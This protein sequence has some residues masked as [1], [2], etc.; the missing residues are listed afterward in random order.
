MRCSLAH[1]PAAWQSG[2]GFL[3]TGGPD[4]TS[5]APGMAVPAETALEENPGPAR[6]V[7]LS[8]VVPGLNEER[9]I[10]ALVERLRPVLDSL[11]LDWE[12]IFVDDGST[13]GTMAVLQVAQRPRSALQG[14]LAQPQ[15]RQGDRGGGRAQPTRRGDAAVLMDADLQHPPELIADF[16]RHWREGADMVYGRR[17][18][19]GSRQPAAPAP[20]AAFLR[21]L[22]AAERHRAAPRGGRLPPARPQGHRRH[23]PH[24]RA[25]ALQQGALRLD[26][27]PLGRRAV[28]RAAPRGGPLALAHRA[29]WRTSPSTGWSRSRPCP[30]GCGP[31]WA[32]SSRCS[33]SAMRWS[34]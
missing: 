20:R 32:S 16:V 9:A 25:R 26:G 29:G 21:R 31:T 13:D 2:N 19:R 12:A 30:S 7:R 8:V 14:G 34:S 3:G 1:G 27:V 23:E 24:G 6:R 18:D 11:D 4:V 5:V 10:P 17:I 15:L 28:Q 22:R 33:R